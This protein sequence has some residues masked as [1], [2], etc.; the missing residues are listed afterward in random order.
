MYSGA[1]GTIMEH[2]PWS[3]GKSPIYPQ[4]SRKVYEGFAITLQT[5][6]E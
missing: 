3:K 1:Y 5:Y 4:F 2:Y 6:A